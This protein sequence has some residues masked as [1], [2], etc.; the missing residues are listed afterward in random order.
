MS[1]FTTLTVSSRAAG[2]AQVTMSRPDVFNAF[3]ETM[4]KELGVY[5][6]QKQNDRKAYDLFNNL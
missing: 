3:D 5:L 6:A 1:S 2:V 4:I